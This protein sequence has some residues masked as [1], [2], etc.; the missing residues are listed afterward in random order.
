MLSTVV[1]VVVVVAVLSFLAAVSTLAVEST[2]VVLVE[3]TVLVDLLPPQATTDN[4][5]T[6]A[7]APNLNEFFM[8]EVFIILSLILA[9]KEGNP[10]N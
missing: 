8:F 3:S 9:Y 5:N 6:N 7:K 1:V 2:V 10:K 4:D